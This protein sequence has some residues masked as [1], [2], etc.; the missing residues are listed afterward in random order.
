MHFCQ[1]CIKNSARNPKKLRLKTEEDIEKNIS[2][3]EIFFMKTLLWT[4][5]YSSRNRTQK[6]CAKCPNSLCSTSWSELEKTFVWEIYFDQKCFL[7][8][9]KSKFDGIARNSRREFKKIYLK[10]PK[11]LRIYTFFQNKI[12]LNLFR[13]HKECNFDNTAEQLPPDVR[14]FLPQ[15]RTRWN[16]RKKVL[17]PKVYLEIILW[18]R[19]LSSRNP[20]EK[21]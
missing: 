19:E 14:N 7:G 8:Y 4:G 5:N 17:T 3:H 6:L 18:H 11:L 20:G 13:S 2:F 1:L 15:I 21:N 10:V 16:S 9:I 12:S